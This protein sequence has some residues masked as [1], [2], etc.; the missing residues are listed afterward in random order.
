MLN[1][2]LS[3]D[4]R[5]YRES[6]L[7]EIEERVRREG[8]HVA[9]AHANRARQFMPFAALKGYHEMAYARE[10]TPEPRREV[11]AEQADALTHAI[12]GL[13]RGDVVRVTHYEDGAYVTTVGA[14]SEVVEAY[15]TIVIVRRRIAF[16]DIWSI[17][18]IVESCDAGSSRVRGAS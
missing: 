17:E 9:R 16:D 7:R 13:S 1:E 4:E 6:K 12:G 11:T 14:V 15:R 18:P 2:R 8:P 3:A 5:R 10:A